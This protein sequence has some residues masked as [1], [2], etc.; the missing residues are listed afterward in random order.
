MATQIKFV[1]NGVKYDLNLAQ[2]AD[3]IGMAKS[4]FSAH[5]R[6]RVS[7][8]DQESFDQIKLCRRIYSPRKVEKVNVRNT[9]A[10]ERDEISARSAI[11][12]VMDRFLFGKCENQRVEI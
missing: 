9:Q 1:Q 6:R 3:L 2:A 11:K 10:I 12:Q 7:D 8:D 4:T 5:W